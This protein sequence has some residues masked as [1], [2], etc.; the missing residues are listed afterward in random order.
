MELTHLLPYCC[1]INRVCTKP[2]PHLCRKRLGVYEDM[3]C[4]KKITGN[5]WNKDLQDSWLQDVCSL[6]IDLYMDSECSQ[7][8][9]TTI[10]QDNLFKYADEAL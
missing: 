4:N 1:Y 6:V 7:T 3:C 10:E 2:F 8:S 9:L 5:D